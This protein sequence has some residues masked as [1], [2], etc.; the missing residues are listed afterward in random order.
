[1][2]YNDFV[3]E[4][5]TT[6]VLETISSFGANPLKQK[7]GSGIS[8]NLSGRD[9]YEFYQKMKTAGSAT[10]GNSSESFQT[11]LYNKGRD[12]FAGGSYEELEASFEKGEIDLD[13]F[14]KAREAMSKKS[15]DKINAIVERISA[16]RKRIMSEYDGELDFDRLYE[17]EPFSNTIR[18]NKGITKVVTINVDFSINCGVSAESIA[19]YGVK[20]WAIA[21]ALERAGIQCEI[22]IVT[23]NN[24]YLG[25]KMNAKKDQSS[26]MHTTI[27]IKQ[28]GEYINMQSLAKYFVPNYYR[29]VIFSLFAFIPNA[30]GYDGCHSLGQGRTEYIDKKNRVRKGVMDLDLEYLAK[31]DVADLLDKVV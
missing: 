8:I 15:A 31:A 24:N 6:K 16:R 3:P 19:D 23:Q 10:L 13:P 12:D 29:R 21:D 5:T 14:F 1:M 11:S 17:R 20:V 7:W 27:G 4:N 22:K 9:T 18:D 2:K 25:S 28:S 26:T 30:L